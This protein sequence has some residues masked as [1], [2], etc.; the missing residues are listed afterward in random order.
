M[1]TKNIGFILLIL[2]IT[3]SACSNAN[4]DEAM[5][6]ANKAID[7]KQ[8]EEAIPHY[9][10]AMEENEKDDIAPFR[11]DQTE[12]FIEGLDALHDGNVDEADGIFNKILSNEDDDAFLQEDAHEQLEEIEALQT[13][14]SE[15]EEAIDAIHQ[16]AE[17]KQYADALDAIDEAKST[18]LTHAYLKPLD[19]TLTDLVETMK[20]GLALKQDKKKI[21]KALEEIKQLGEDKKYKDAITL[22]D[23]TLD[24]DMLNETKET[25]EADLTTLKKEYEE[26]LAAAIQAQKE[27]EAAEKRLKSMY[28]FWQHET[29][30]N[31]FIYIQPT[32]FTNLV[33]ASDVSFQVSVDTYSFDGDTF[34][35]HTSDGEQISYTHHDNELIALQGSYY[36]VTKE[37]MKQSYPAVDF[38]D[39]KEG[40]LDAFMGK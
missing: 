23:D 2:F 36:K 40:A 28:G 27:K 16:L 12:Q 20:D 38:D 26:A 29:L 17:E 39:F 33:Y 21:K 31:D 7:D 35:V 22:I 1:P 32:Y 37:E 4:Y 11:R 9:E 3:L 34:I 13:T 19:E 30:V 10:R 24:Q 5:E 15:T 18:D 6:K 25:F 14:F 8:Y